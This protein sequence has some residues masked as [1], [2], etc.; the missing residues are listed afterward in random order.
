MAQSGFTPI[1]LYY[2]TTAAQLPL[3]A[4]LAS[5]ELAINITDGK[6]YFKNSSN[7][8]TKIADQSAATGSVSG[9]TA[10]DIVYQSAPSTSAFLNIG[11]NGYVL[12][13][14]GSLPT[15]TNPASLTVGSATTATNIASGTAGQLLYQTGAGATGFA[16]APVSGYV[17]SWNGSAYQWIVGVPS[18]STA[19]LSGGGA[20]TVV[21]QSATGT[22]AYL[23]NGTTG[24]VL[25]ANTGAAPSWINQSTMSVG[26]AT[27]ATTATNLAN[28]LIGN[29]PYQSGAG[30]TSFLA[31]S[32]TSGYLLTSGGAGAPTWTNPT[33][34][35]TTN[36]KL[37]FFGQF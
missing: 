7:V 26:S 13:S 34:V 11:T 3:A 5:G 24:Q 23:T 36:G 31:S 10:G 35:S 16:A 25:N 29:I 28:G 30:A 19:N 21:Y 2:S 20:Y 6:M 32:G 27:N 33:T 4:N 9:G 17:L 12:T 37:Y 1:K 15:Y 22:T 8:V 14:T 18:S